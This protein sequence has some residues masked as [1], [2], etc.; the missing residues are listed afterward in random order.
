MIQFE[1]VNKIYKDKHQ[2][3]YALKN[4][5]FSIE[6]GE[7]LGVIG[8]N[9][10]GKTTMF[11]IL[12]G[13]LANDSGRVII[14][15]K[16]KRTDMISYLP[17]NRGLDSR[18]IVKE[19]LSDLLGFKGIKMSEARVLVKKWLKEFQMEE[20]SDSKIE[21]LSKGNQQKIQ[22]I[23]AI[24]NNPEILIL[25]EPF[26]GLDVIATDFF[27]EM[28]KNVK[29]QGTT[30]IF[31]THNLQDKMLLCKKFLFLTKGEIAKYGTIDEIQNDF[32]KMLEIESK[33]VEKEKLFQFIS[34]KEQKRYNIN[35][36]IML[37]N[38]DMAKELFHKLGNPY[39]EKFLVRKQSLEEIFREVNGESL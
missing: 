33:E 21:S 10:A 25:D 17:E 28:I 20:Y 8:R 19:H 24:A 27:W 30:I 34:A 37:E 7:I 38:D 1:N 5:S 4:V 18:H 35:G 22:F 39:C 13:I 16:S 12:S 26:S 15:N 3:K 32:K 31:S 9:G 36:C 29:S 6:Q 11:K 23:S 14:E 2:E